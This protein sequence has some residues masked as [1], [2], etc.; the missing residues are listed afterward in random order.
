[1]QA[2]HAASERKPQRHLG[3]GGRRVALYA[4]LPGGRLVHPR[5]RVPVGRRAVRQGPAHGYQHATSRATPIC[6]R[7][8]RKTSSEPEE[9]R[10][11]H[12]LVVSVLPLHDQRLHLRPHARCARWPATAAVQP[13][14]CHLHRPGRLRCARPS[15][16]N[17][18]L[19]L[20]GDTVRAKL[21]RRRHPAAHPGQPA[22]LC[23]WTPTGRAG[24][25]QVRVGAGGPPNRV[26]RRLKPAPVATAC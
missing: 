4:R 2:Q 13:G 19:S 23:G 1:M 16:G 25:G 3:I 26:R 22:R 17:L 24:K 6:S 7:R 15:T 18:G 8:P 9:D 20:F 12:H 14:R 5:Q 11:R 10:W 21:R